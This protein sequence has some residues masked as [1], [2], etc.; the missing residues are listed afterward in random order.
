MPDN[1]T[2]G[3]ADRLADGRAAL[4]L[5]GTD[6]GSGV[7]HAEWRVGRRRDPDPAPPAVVA[8]EG[9]QTLQTRVVDKAGNAS[10]WRNE[11]VKVDR[12]KPTNT[13]PRPR[14]ASGATRTTR[15]PSPART[16]R[17]ACAASSGH[18]RR[19]RDSSTSPTVAITAEGTHKL[20]DSRR[21]RRRQRL[22]LA[23]RHDRHR[24]DR[25][26]AGRRLRHHRLAQH[27]GAP[28]RSPPTAGSPAWPTL[29]ARRRDA[30]SRSTGGA[31]P[32][33]PRAPPRSTSVPSTAPATTA[34]RGRR[35]RSTPRRRP[36]AATCVPDA[37]SLKY[38]CTAA[39][40]DA[41]VRRRRASPG[42]STAGAATPI[43]N[44]GTFTV[45]KGKVVVYASDAAGNGAASRLR[46][47]S[48]IAAAP[49]PDA[50][51]AHRAARPCSCA[52]AAA[53]PPRL[54]RPAR[55]VS[56]RRPRRRSTCG[57]SRSARARSSSSSRSSCGK[58]TK[59]F[60]KTQ[61]SQA[62]YS[63]RISV[64]AAA[65]PPTARSR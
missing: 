44:G 26:D 43:A 31:T 65:R 24:Q 10:A 27:A 30:P 11:T 19:R 7:D 20:Y 36:L 59:T 48:P 64:K 35:S 47:C 62:G 3:R 12:T 63:K 57:R 29:T 4:D 6:D 55:A 28:A 2:A 13:T 1:T 17:P 32:S 5:T 16:R 23:R 14:A 54:R 46:S 53:R 41:A 52:R 56:T 33:A 39:A 22:R 8:T 37:G 18:A 21:R 49:A 45:A 60:T 9:T 51:P 34:R 50:D 58:K 40:T 25:A 42:R 61:T 15:R 38:T